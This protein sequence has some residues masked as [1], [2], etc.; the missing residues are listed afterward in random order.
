MVRKVFLEEMAFE[1]RPEQRAVAV[2]PLEEQKKSSPTGKY[3]V[4]R[5]WSGNELGLFRGWQGGMDG[6]GGGG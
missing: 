3:H 4:R 2:Q 1:Q 5:L 6:A